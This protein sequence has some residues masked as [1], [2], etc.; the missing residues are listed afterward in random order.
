MTTKKTP[1]T[2]DM[3]LQTLN[4]LWLNT[5]DKRFASIKKEVADL[6]VEY[7]NAKC[8]VEALFATGAVIAKAAQKIWVRDGASCA[9]CIVKQSHNTISLYADGNSRQ[10]RDMGLEVPHFSA[11]RLHERDRTA[12]TPLA[13]AFALKEGELN[14]ES[15]YVFDFDMPAVALVNGNCHSNLV[16]NDK[17]YVK[18]F[19][20]IRTRCVRV[21]KDANEALKTLNAVLAPCKYVE[22]LKAQLPSIDKYIPTPEAKS[23]GMVLIADVVKFDNLLK[24]YQ[25]KDANVD[26]NS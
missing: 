16:I 21:L 25:T 6:A 13:L 4:A 7:I 18:R 23:F 1:L 22:D 15:K 14:T 10:T 11:Y 5:F 20:A 26:T 3:K 19:E 24:E 12:F 9:P 17:N 2:R 8:D